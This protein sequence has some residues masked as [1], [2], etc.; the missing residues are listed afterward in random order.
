ML[1]G[2]GQLRRQPTLVE[3]RC[4]RHTVLSLDAHRAAAAA[5][6]PEEL[7]ARDHLLQCVEFFTST[8]C[9]DLLFH[10]SERTF[11][12][13]EMQ[14]MLRRVGCAPLGVFF[15]SLDV[16]A[17]ARQAYRSLV[18]QEAAA[19]AVNGSPGA[20]GAPDDQQSDLARWHRV[21]MANPGVFGRMHI[22]Y[23]QKGWQ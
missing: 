8:G 3:L 10:P 11:T 21:E 7:A 17:I 23:A 19:A 12:L 13:L 6:P 4:L 9:R 18:A 16:D 15:A 2:A 5:L 1:H 14:Q 22:V 20:G